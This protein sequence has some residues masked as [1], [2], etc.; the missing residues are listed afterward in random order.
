VSPQYL[1]GSVSNPLLALAAQTGKVQLR[2][3]IA[4][5]NNLRPDS[6]MELKGVRIGTVNEINIISEQA[7][8]IRFTVFQDKLLIHPANPSRIQRK[9]NLRLKIRTSLTKKHSM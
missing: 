9:T 1:K 4:N 6:F 7:V 8:E 2:G 5:V 3:R